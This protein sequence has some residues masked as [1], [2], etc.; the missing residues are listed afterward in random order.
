[1]YNQI[2]HGGV[3]IL[4]NKLFMKNFLI[5][6]AISFVI[7]TFY[8]IYTVTEAH[9]NM[10]RKA[11]KNQVALTFDDGPKNKYTEYTDELLGVLKRKDVKATF[12]VLGRDVALN[13]FDVKKIFDAGHVVANHAYSHD[14]LLLKNY[15]EILQEL[16]SCSQ[17]IETITGKR[18]R[19]VRPPFGKYNSMVLKAF[20]N[21]GLTMV[22]WTNNPGDYQ[23][24]DM[25]RELAEEILKFRKPGDII[26]LH[27]GVPLTIEAVEI[28]IDAYREA[29]CEFITVEQI[30]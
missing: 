1:M 21:E 25:G 8:D 6:I 15:D 13:S 28:I 20:E 7:L 14:N 30:K 3:T 16:R 11:G 17:L 26:L 9:S 24:W 18:P 4:F 22:H 23:G 19:Y 27:L 29:G 2:R 10:I 5:F 12:F